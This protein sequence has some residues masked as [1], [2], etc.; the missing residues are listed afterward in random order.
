MGNERTTVTIS[1][2]QVVRHCQAPLAGTLF[3]SPS[4]G[5]NG[6]IG[7]GFDLDSPI[8]Y[9]RK[10]DYGLHG[11]DFFRDN[12]VTLAPGEAQ[13]FDIAVRTSQHYCQFTFQMTVATPNGMVTENIDDNG[14]PFELTAK[15]KLDYATEYIGGIEAILTLR[16]P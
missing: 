13:T 10:Y 7:I 9:A 14:R 2:L 6:T 11:G 3:L 5:L 15:A 1:D 16:P 8:Y 4:Q 12:V